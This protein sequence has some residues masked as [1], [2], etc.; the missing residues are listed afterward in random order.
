MEQKEKGRQLQAAKHQHGMKLSCEVEEKS[1]SFLST[2]RMKQV[3]LYFLT[4]IKILLFQASLYALYYY[5]Y[6]LIILLCSITGYMVL[7]DKR[8]E[9]RPKLFSIISIVPIIIGSI[10]IHFYIIAGLFLYLIFYLFSEDKKWIK[11]ITYVIG[12]V[13]VI[14]SVIDYYSL[15]YSAHPF[16]IIPIIVCFVVP[17][18]SFALFYATRFSA[19]FFGIRIILRIIS[20]YSILIGVFI[21]AIVPMAYIYIIRGIADVSFNNIVEFGVITKFFL[22]VFEKVDDIKSPNIHLFKIDRNDILL[23][24]RR[25]SYDEKEDPCLAAINDYICQPMAPHYTVLKIADPSTFYCY[26]NFGCEFLYLPTTNWKQTLNSYI[27]KASLVVMVLDYSEGVLWEAFEHHDQKE[28]YIYY[29][30]SKKQLIDI[31]NDT[32]FYFQKYDKTLLGKYLINYY[33]EL[34]KEPNNSFPIYL[35]FIEEV[36]LKEDNIVDIIIKKRSAVL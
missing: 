22:Y 28:K 12:G 36:L 3:A 19:Y 18:I 10:L 15:V 17:V 21:L 7:G 1:A 8:V 34:N 5:E 35:Y 23:F 2:S 30:P 32:L 20:L 14:C 13:L 9:K 4:L 27:E 25:F 29:L 6:W 16:F 26:K 24:L 31:V 11:Y 33:N